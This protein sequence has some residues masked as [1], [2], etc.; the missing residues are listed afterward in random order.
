M[1]LHHATMAHKKGLSAMEKFLSGLAVIA[2]ILFFTCPTEE[3][4][5][6]AVDD[7]VSE[8]FEK[9]L[10]E[11]P[12][13]ALGAALYMGIL[14]AAANEVGIRPFRVHGYKNWWI[15]STAKIE[16]DTTFGILAHVFIIDKQSKKKQT[17]RPQSGSPA[18]TS[19]YQG[20]RKDIK[21]FIDE[22]DGC[23]IAVITE[24]GGDVA[25]C[26][27]DGYCCTPSCPS[28]LKKALKE[29]NGTGVR[30][31][32]V[33]LTDAGRY[34]V[35]FGRNGFSTSVDIPQ[36]MYDALKRYRT[37]NE[38]LLHAA[39]NDSGEWVVVS[40]KHYSASRA[41]MDWLKNR[42]QEYGDVEYV[43]LTDNGRIALCEKGVMADGIYSKVLWEAM[44]AANFNI[45]VVKMAGDSWFFVPEKGG[46]KYSM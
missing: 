33:C 32:D 46:Y 23:R 40:D 27:Q 36:G 15:F 35:L 29:I 45:K 3:D 30:I 24:K 37:N 4:H 26:G 14:G 5:Q 44:G 12:D 19:K 22:Q 7:K 18:R 16:N 11:N 39:L 25:I 13:S 41:L 20:K 17:A 34:V 2:V 42:P 21:E 6:K 28:G 31:T 38:A 8:F 9:G 10:S 1:L 43:A